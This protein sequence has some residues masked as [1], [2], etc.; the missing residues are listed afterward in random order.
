VSGKVNR[1]LTYLI[2]VLVGRAEPNIMGAALTVDQLM[3]QKQEDCDVTKYSARKQPGARAA[4]QAAEQLASVQ[5]AVKYLGGLSFTVISSADPLKRY[6]VN[7]CTD[8][9]DCLA[10]RVGRH[11]KHMMACQL[12][13]ARDHPALFSHISCDR[14]YVTA[15]AQGLINGATGAAAAADNEIAEV[16]VEEVRERC[17]LLVVGFWVCQ[18]MCRVCW[19]C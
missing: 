1:S 19:R 4:Q 3:Q 10:N 5:G 12:V 13:L 11:C 7:L 2:D 17:V 9:C 6:A 14:E 15:L 18:S 16:K 8:I